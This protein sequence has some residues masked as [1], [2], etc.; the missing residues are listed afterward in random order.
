MS[1]LMTKAHETNSRMAVQEVGMQAQAI[2]NMTMLKAGRKL[3]TGQM[4]GLNDTAIAQAQGF[5]KWM[6]MLTDKN[7][8]P[9]TVYNEAAKGFDAQFFKRMTPMAFIL[10]RW[11]SDPD[12]QPAAQRYIKY[13]KSQSDLYQQTNGAQ[14]S[15]AYQDIL[16]QL[17]YGDQ[18]GLFA[19]VSAAANQ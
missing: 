6:S 14:G 9:G 16:A 5:S 10:H 11:M 15:Q 7:T 17:N 12:T 18:S 8:D 19:S 3:V 2:P 4:Q 1:M 13:L